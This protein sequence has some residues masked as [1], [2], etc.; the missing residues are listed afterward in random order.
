M[1]AIKKASRERRT[2]AMT[3]I[4]DRTIEKENRLRTHFEALTERFKDEL[5]ASKKE[6]KQEDY[7]KRLYEREERLR[8]AEE[9]ESAMDFLAPLAT[10][11]FSSVSI[12]TNQIDSMRAGVKKYMKQMR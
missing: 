12:K 3:K 8:I 6:E 1:G 7:L 9:R 4:R 11:A 5:M 10:N 2:N